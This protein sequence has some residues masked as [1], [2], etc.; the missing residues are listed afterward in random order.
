MKASFEDWRN[1]AL[2]GNL[3]RSVDSARHPWLFKGAVYLQVF[4]DA[5]G[6]R[7][8]QGY[9]TIAYGRRL[10]MMEN[11]CLALLLAGARVRDA[12]VLCEGGQTPL[13]LQP[14]G[15]A[16]ELIGDSYVHGMMEGEL[17][18]PLELMAMSIV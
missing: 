15:R 17:F 10:G 7:E 14:M 5:L 3:P 16:F 9:A 6:E 2:P 4:Q 12:V 8:E 18:R 13:I 1:N 11:S